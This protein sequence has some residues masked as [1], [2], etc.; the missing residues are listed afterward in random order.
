MGFVT[1]NVHE[2]VSQRILPCMV[3]HSG[4]FGSVFAC[5]VLLLA[6]RP[7]RVIGLARLFPNALNLHALRCPGDRFAATDPATDLDILTDSFVTVVLGDRF[8]VLGHQCLVC[9]N[10][11]DRSRCP[12]RSSSS[13]FD[14]RCFCSMHLGLTPCRYIPGRKVEKTKLRTLDSPE[15]KV[16]LP[17]QQWIC[18]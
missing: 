4:W 2:I 1:F 13:S 11:C 5:C 7:I 6:W 16:L 10:Y 8:G 18:L 9:G 3:T 15:I 14:A 17:N 12:I